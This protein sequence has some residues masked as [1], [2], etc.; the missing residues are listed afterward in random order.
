MECPK[1]K[2]QCQ[3]DQRYCGHCGTVDPR[4]IAIFT[5]LES[6]FN[7]RLAEIQKQS[8]ENKKVIENEI[9]E[10]VV[11]RILGWGK[12][13]SWMLGVPVALL[14]VILGYFGIKSLYDLEVLR[15][16]ISARAAEADSVKWRVDSMKLRL[17]SSGRVLRDI[18]ILSTT[19]QRINKEMGVAKDSVN[20]VS[21]GSIDKST[22][23][24]ALT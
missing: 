13:A 19:V 3:E 6:S 22:L 4:M 23:A 16:K 10:R 18:E 5:N 14:V 7:S 8:V 2:S 20:S 15:K 24:R 1:C 11:E 21:Q 17:S 12:I 9:T